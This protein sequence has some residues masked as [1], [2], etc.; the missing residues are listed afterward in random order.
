MA[1]TTVENR[2]LTIGSPKLVLILTQLVLKV[3]C[4]KF[5]D[6]HKLLGYSCY[7]EMECNQI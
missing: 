5:V 4:L 6:N 2:K 7:L 3:T 1:V